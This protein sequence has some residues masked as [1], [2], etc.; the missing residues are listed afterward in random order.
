M[1]TSHI[2]VPVASRNGELFR[3]YWGSSVP[4]ETTYSFILLPPSGIKLIGIS[5]ITTVLDGRIN[6][7]H[8]V[9]GSGYTIAE[10]MTGYNYDETLGS[11][12]QSSLY[13][14]TGLTGSSQRCAQVPI[15][16]PTSGPVRDES[17]QTLIEAQPTYDA[18]NFAVF[19]YE[20]PGA[21][22]VGLWFDVSWLEIE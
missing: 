14:V 21:S 4:A 5:R 6:A 7:C 8:G 13:R 17:V 1:A 19:N 15:I 18:S 22:A 10:T 3:T 2:N 16:A 9:G 11:T 20:N 12:A